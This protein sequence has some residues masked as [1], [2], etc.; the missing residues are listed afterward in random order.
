MAASSKSK[1]GVGIFFS[2]S[3][4]DEELRDEL[5]KHLSLLRRQGIVIGWHDR[6][7]SPGKEWKGEINTHLEKALI[8]LPLISPDFIASD[9]CYDVEMRRALERHESG[10]SR[11]IPIILRAVSW[12]SAPFGRLQALPKNGHPVTSWPNRD[13]AFRNIAEGITR[14]AE[15]LI[16]KSSSGDISVFRSVS[17]R[18]EKVSSDLRIVR[19][20]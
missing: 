20:T 8:I 6:R 4:Q 15:E 13:E 14:V 17:T 12:E 3:H 5:E 10:E 18:S 9:Y 7:I 16:G 11:V 19:F 1:K 2:Y